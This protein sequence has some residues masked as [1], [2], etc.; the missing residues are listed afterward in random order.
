MLR[1]PD[2]ETP[3]VPRADVFLN[4]NGEFTIKVE[5]AAL[6]RDDVELSIQ[7]QGVRITGHRPDTDRAAGG[8]RYVA[9]GISWGWFDMMVEVPAEFDLARATARYQNGLL[10]V[11]VPQKNESGQGTG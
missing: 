9:A 3:W 11:L 2:S 4:T 1:D 5:L 7:G 10:R 8:S 6:S